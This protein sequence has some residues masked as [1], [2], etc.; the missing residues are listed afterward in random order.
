M[1]CYYRNDISC[2]ANRMEFEDQ[3]VIKGKLD[4][5]GIRLIRVSHFG[6]FWRAFHE[7]RKEE[8]KKKKKRISGMD[9]YGFVW[10]MMYGLLW[11]CMVYDV[12]IC[13]DYYGLVCMFGLLYGY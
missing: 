1:K 8:K 9:Y 4:Q 10:F 7:E 13:M 3:S 5:I 11:V 12:W 6:D 2:G